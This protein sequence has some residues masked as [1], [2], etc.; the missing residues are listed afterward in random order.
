MINVFLRRFFFCV[1]VIKYP[2]RVHV[3]VPVITGIVVNMLTHFRSLSVPP[4]NKK[5]E[6]LDMF[7]NIRHNYAF[8][9]KEKQFFLKKFCISELQQLKFLTQK[10]TMVTQ[11][12]TA[13]LSP[14]FHSRKS[15]LRK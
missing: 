1:C 14:N 9:E 7:K 8:Q 4:E 2:L 15:Y 10:E 11:I 5:P 3:L 6:A 13:S 12:S